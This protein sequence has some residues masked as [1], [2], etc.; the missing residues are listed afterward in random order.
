[1]AGTEIPG[2]GGRGRLYLTLH[3]Q[4]L[5]DSCIKMG[6]SES[7]FDCFIKC[8]G[9]SHKTVSREHNFSRVQVAGVALFLS[10]SRE[11]G[12]RWRPLWPL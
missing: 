12:E 5:N 1:M 2:G 10:V 4:H 7:H 11:G 3:C 9:E 8:Y 6:G